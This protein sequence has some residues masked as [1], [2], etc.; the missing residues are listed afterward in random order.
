MSF[1]PSIKSLAQLAL[2][3][4]QMLLGSS[5][6]SVL[7]SPLEACSQ[8]HLSCHAAHGPVNTCCTPTPGGQIAL[9][10]F[11]NSDASAGQPGYVGPSDSWTLHGLWPDHC[12]GTY[13][14][15][16]DCSRSGDCSSRNRKCQRHAC[17][18]AY[19][20][21]TAILER[22]EQHDLLALMRAHW[23][24]IAGDEHLWQH[25]WSKH[26]TCVSTLEPRCY[27]D[28]SYRETEEVVDYFAKAV[29]LFGTV[30][31]YQWLADAGI[32]PSTERTY[33][34]AEIREALGQARGVE[35]VVG[36]Q[37]N[38]LREV[39]YH[40]EVL[41]TVQTGDFIPINPDF[42]GTH[43]PGKGCPSTG[44]KY[45]PKETSE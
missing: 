1:L 31:T 15:V 27:G 6:S 36:C 16:C 14:S 21:I 42:T 35:A 3:G 20:N 39:W 26:G 11:W 22:L 45:L 24:G 12:T 7:Q 25:E 41:G 9:T 34:L 10:Q 28:H 23:K 2:T 18:R 19:S 29:E 5:P 44:I 33:E 30:P 32:V 13:D 37:R 43:G 4:P 38:E 40:Y 17:N 8:P